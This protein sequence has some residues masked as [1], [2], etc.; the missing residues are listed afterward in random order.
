VTEVQDQNLFSELQQVE[1]IS[2][3]KILGELLKPEHKRF[4]TEIDAPLVV[5]TLDLLAEHLKSFGLDAVLKQWLSN[6]RTNMIAYKRKRSTEIV[7]AIIAREN[8]E[9]QKREIR[10]IMLGE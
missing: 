5:S 1:E 2:T 7:N 8:V 6:F 4:H 10:D 3:E 9:K